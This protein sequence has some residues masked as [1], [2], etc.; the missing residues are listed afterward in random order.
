MYGLHPKVLT[1]VTSL[2]LPH[3]VNEVGLNFTAFM[4]SLHENVKCK[5]E[6]Q[7]AKY[8]AQANHHRKDIQFEEGDLVLIRLRLERF[9][10]EIYN[11]LHARR[12]GPF[13]ILKKLETNSYLVDLPTEF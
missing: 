7:V 4:F 6:E 3:K 8:I 2:P 9:P 5:M 13:K 10:T 1:D 12:D 11:K